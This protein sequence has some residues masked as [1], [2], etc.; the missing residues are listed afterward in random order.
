MHLSVLSALPTNIF[1]NIFY[2]HILNAHD[3]LFKSKIHLI[4]IWDKTTTRVRDA[5]LTE[6]ARC[7]LCCQC[8]RINISLTLIPSIRTSAINLKPILFILGVYFSCKWLI[9]SAIIPLGQLAETETAGTRGKLIINYRKSLRSGR[10]RRH[11]IKPA[12]DK[13]SGLMHRC[14]E[15]WKGWWMTDKGQTL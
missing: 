1:L 7:K 5:I 4:N 13:P 9:R 11:L 10:A 15:N 14:V 2:N 3:L 12:A 6:S 8:R